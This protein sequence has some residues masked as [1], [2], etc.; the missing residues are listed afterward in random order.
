[1]REAGAHEHVM[2]AGR[3]APDPGHFGE[4]AMLTQRPIAG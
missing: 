4:R 3:V 2:F 1:M